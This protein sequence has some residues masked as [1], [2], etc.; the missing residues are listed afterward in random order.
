MRKQLSIVLVEGDHL[1]RELSALLVG[2]GVW[3]KSTWSTGL[4]EAIAQTT[5]H[6]VVCGDP[7]QLPLLKRTIADHH[8]GTPLLLIADWDLTRA[9]RAVSSGLVEDLIPDS[10]PAV[11]IARRLETLATRRATRMPSRSTLTPPTRAGIHPLLPVGAGREDRT[12]ESRQDNPVPS[13]RPPPP[14][15]RVMSVPPAPPS[16][17]PPRFTRPTQPHSIPPQRLLGQHPSLAPTTTSTYPQQA[18]PTQA[19]P[20]QGF[21]QQVYAAQSYSAQS[22][23]APASV[24]PSALSPDSAP[25][26]QMLTT[27]AGRPSRRPRSSGPGF[28]LGAALGVAASAAAFVGVIEFEHDLRRVAS[29]SMAEVQHLVG[30]RE[31]RLPK[32]LAAVAKYAR[33]GRAAAQPKAPAALA[34]NPAPVAAAHGAT[35]L[36]LEDLGTVETNALG[37][38]QAEVDALFKVEDANLASCEQ[39]LVGWEAPLPM[40][41]EDRPKQ[42]AIHRR[43][44]QT[45]LVAG[46]PM[47]ALR[48]LCKSAAIDPAGAGTETLANVYLSQRSLE[49][50]ETWAKRFL[51]DNSK[52]ESGR[53]L[54]G[55]IENQRGKVAEARAAWL[56]V[57]GLDPS[58]E[59]TMREVARHYVQ[60]ATSAM[61]ASDLAQAER[62]LRRA[63]TLDPMNTSAALLLSRVLERQ[64]LV[65]PSLAWAARARELAR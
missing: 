20:A 15:V 45:H 65:A 49:H 63:L 30:E 17:A 57:L 39:M 23:S 58:Q 5:P 56:S 21:P 59:G 31:T 33:G 64:G 50:A 62:K 26:I 10:L 41:E 8:P 19:Y 60:D 24:P 13:R 2:M 34:Q 53:E 11:D 16:A 4:E 7:S 42:G 3:V 44:A 35:A 29:S 6:L 9:G 28:T 54:L 40:I 37:L 18:Y 12:P 55:D 46:E 52:S 47:Q 51:A 27:T 14:P 36:E 48:D 61:G 38:S 25:P 43:Q 1:P 32:W 22:Y